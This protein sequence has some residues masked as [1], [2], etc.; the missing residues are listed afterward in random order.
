MLAVHRV[1]RTVSRCFEIVAGLPAGN[2]FT[3]AN[4]LLDHVLACGP[5][6]ARQPPPVLHGGNRLP[7]ELI[8]PVVAALREQQFL[9]ERGYLA[10]ST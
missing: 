7:P 9:P 1:E 10:G 4:K 8:E 6:A 3:N 2:P 5:D